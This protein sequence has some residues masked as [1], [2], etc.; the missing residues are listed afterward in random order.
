MSIQPQTE[1]E[2]ETSFI[3]PDLLALSSAFPFGD[4]PAYV[5]TI[6]SRS[7]LTPEHVQNPV[8]L[9]ALTNG[10]IDLG[11]LAA[12]V[13]PNASPAG[14]DASCELFYLIT[15]VDDTSDKQ[16]G[17][18]AQKTVESFLNVLRDPHCDDGTSLAR[19][20]RAFCE[21]LGPWTG[22]PAFARFRR[23]CES[24]LKH[25]AEEATL[26]ESGTMLSFEE[27]TRLR[28]ESSAVQVGLALMEFSLGM[29][30]PDEV[31]KD[32]DFEALYWAT[33][34]LNCIDVYSYRRER[35]QG[36]DMCNI[37]TVLRHDKGLTLQG[38]SDWMGDHFQGLREA[39][40]AARRTLS[41]RT[42]GNAQTDSDLQRLL[43]EFGHWTTGNIVW[44]FE[45]KRYFGEARFKVMETRLVELNS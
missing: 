5:P 13:N 42:F 38:A 39:F 37:L 15:L 32:E 30:L 17:A 25:T 26:R 20:T 29:N 44:C 43:T 1:T 6:E 12:L 33:V 16:S 45:T 36:I 19:I 3:L 34:D 24:W 18:G 23:Q 22:T 27:F 40:F 8:V 31:Y 14:L 35:S 28:R 21:R 2:T 41:A 9:A 7:W 11:R 10:S 4:N